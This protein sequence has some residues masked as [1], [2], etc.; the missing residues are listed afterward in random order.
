MATEQHVQR[1]TGQSRW[2]SFQ[3]TG[4]R[5]SAAAAV[6]TRELPMP[7]IMRG[8][9]HY[10]AMLLSDQFGRR[11]PQLPPYATASPAS[12]EALL[13]IGK[14]SQRFL[15]GEWQEQTSEAGTEALALDARM[16]VAV[17]SVGVLLQRHRHSR[18]L[19]RRSHRHGP[20]PVAL[21][22]RATSS[23]KYRQ[24]DK[25]NWSIQRSP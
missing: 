16:A 9:G 22:Y 8:H 5:V 19:V 23:M 1:A 4:S 13:D 12:E 15:A 17:E 21:P 7:D 3:A 6:A 25:R 18:G 10:S 24:T 2:T 14:D 20:P 11:F